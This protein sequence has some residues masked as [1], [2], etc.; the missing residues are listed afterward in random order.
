M[1]IEPVCSGCHRVAR[2]ALFAFV[3]A[4]SMP[5][6]AAIV[7]VIEY[8]NAGLVRYFVTVDPTE[9]AALDAG[10]FGGAWKRTGNTFSAWDIAGA[11]TGTVPVC[12]FFGTDR[13]RSDGSRIGPN[14]HFY[15]ADP[16][17]CEFVK[18]AWQS[19]AADGQSYP[20]WTF[21]T[22]AF[23]VELR[24]DSTCRGGTQPLSRT[25]NHGAGGGPNH[26]YATNPALLEA[27]AGWVFEGLVMCLP[28]SRTFYVSS[29]RGD[30]TNS[31]A[32]VAPF[33][34]IGRGVA[35]G[36]GVRRGHGARRRWRLQRVAAPVLEC[37]TDRCPQSRHVV[38]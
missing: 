23:A 32:Q 14:S 10:A 16:H 15:T 35:C 9:I 31:G 5:S 19:V 21:E 29:S 38:D 13:Y 17:E 8:Y 30:D 7:Q 33:A 18:T 12:R 27:M 24:G 3:A 6:S 11:P 4:V 20:A 25:Y 1:M 37:G 34:T 26:R 2:W 28:Q 36:H 22:H